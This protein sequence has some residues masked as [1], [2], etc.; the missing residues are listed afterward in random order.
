MYPQPTNLSPSTSTSAP[1]PTSIFEPSSTDQQSTESSPQ[2]SL[3]CGQRTPA[4]LTSSSDAPSSHTPP[5]PFVHSQHQPKIPT[6]TQHTS[7]KPHKQQIQQTPVKTNA[8]QP[9]QPSISDEEQQHVPKSTNSSQVKHSKQQPRQQEECLCFYCNQLGH[10]KRNCPE[11]PYCSKC[12]TRG[13]TP[14]RCTSKPQKNRH[15][16]QTGESRDQQ[17]R[18][19]DLPQFSSRHNSCLH[20]AGDPQTANCTTTQ[21]WQAPTTNSPAS[22][23]G[24]S[25]HQNA[26][27]TSHS[28]SQS[29][30]QSPASHQHS[31]STLHVQTPTL[32][33]NAP[34]FQS[35]LHQAPP[36]P[37]AQNNQSTNYHTNQQQMH[38]PPTQPFNAQL[39][40][41]FNSHVPP[42]YFP[43]YLPTNS[44]SAHSTDSSILLALQKQWERQERLDMERNEM[45]KQKEERKRMKEEREQ[46]KEDRKQV[47][48]CKNQQKS[49]INKA[50]EKIPRFDGTN[51][52]YCFDW[53][54]QTEALV[55]KH[56]GRIYREE[57]LLNCGTSMSK[58]IH[59]LPQGATNQNI[60]DVV[61][62]N[63]SNLRTMSQQL[64]AY[65]QLHQKPDEALQTYNTRYA[66]F[67]NLAYPEL[68]LDN[69]LSR[70]HCI[71]YASSLYGKL[72]D[73]MTGRFNQDLPENLQT[74]FEKATNFEPRIITKQS[75]NNR[76]IHEVN[77]IDITH[78][79][80]EVEI[81]EAHV[82]NPNYKGKNYDPN[83]QQNRTKTTNTTN[84]ASSHH[85]NTN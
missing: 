49:R 60:K 37:L 78:G 63:H 51:P 14:D 38:T 64:N 34:Q 57:L 3:P 74:A 40:Q 70:M 39:P 46:R 53:L 71:H 68:E 5:Q 33:I 62:R 80:D 4:A 67:F 23:T 54:E 65:H 29:N 85:N 6:P 79:E 56:Q 28:S 8:N 83:Y 30:A 58:M 27:N 13:H 43:Q 10:L 35:N 22:G 18:N 9:T 45:E 48:K 19:E 69:P 36:P 26:P 47:E 52:S 24:T 84:N 7:P 2:S 55:N 42:A 59:A 17:E 81:N 25:I 1:K 44:P 16:R 12:R 11:I 21:Q 50:F 41:S 66:S 20:C 31:Q 75:I 82:R 32:N 76:K 77:H 15:T 61:L 72:R 73:E